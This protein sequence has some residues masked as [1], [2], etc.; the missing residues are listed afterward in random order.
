MQ[1]ERG[2][3]AGQV[4]RR[5]SLLAARSNVDIDVRPAKDGFLVGVAGYSRLMHVR[6]STAH[7]RSR[8]RRQRSFHPRRSR[9]TLRRVPRG[10]RMAR[11]R[12]Q[13]VTRQGRRTSPNDVWA[14]PPEGR[15]ADIS[16]NVEDRGQVG[17]RPCNH[18]S[19]LRTFPRIGGACDA[20]HGPQ[21]AR[22]H[23]ASSPRCKLR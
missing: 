23:A 1:C 9:A 20:H 3:R 17:P 11:L 19:Q 4:H 21:G 10:W 13:G 7:R 16:R 15:F 8:R 2:T 18:W 22:I 12:P 5:G 6:F 14:R